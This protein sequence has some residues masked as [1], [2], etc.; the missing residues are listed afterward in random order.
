MKG[1]GNSEKQKPDR[2]LD[3]R[4]ENSHL[5]FRRSERAVQRIPRM[6]SLK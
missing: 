3:N 1:I 2:R 4:A 6:G 5:P